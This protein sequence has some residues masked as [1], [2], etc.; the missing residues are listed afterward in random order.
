M[1]ELKYDVG[2]L[3][4]VGTVL[5]DIEVE[6]E[7]DEPSTPKTAT[8]PAKMKA[9]EP[10]LPPTPAPTPALPPTP[11]HTAPTPVVTHDADHGGRVLTTPSGE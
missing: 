4:H 3:A 9:P 8:E 1:K 7:V 11:V 2:Q 6:G 10:V 5:I